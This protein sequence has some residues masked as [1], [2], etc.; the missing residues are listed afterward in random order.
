MGAQVGGRFVGRA[1]ELARLHALIDG[2]ERLITLVGPPG[3]GKTRLA[4]ELLAGRAEA[5]FCAIGQ[6]LDEE[7]V[8]RGLAAGLGVTVPA[9][10]A[11]SVQLARVLAERGPWVVV[12][13]NAEQVTAPLRALVDAWVAYAPEVRFVVTSRERLGL[14]YEVSHEL[15]ALPRA[16]EFG[17][18]SDAHVLLLDRVARAGKPIDTSLAAGERAALQRLT[19][20]LGGLPLAIEL[21][22]PR[23]ALLGAVAVEKRLAERSDLL[24]L[25]PL[26]T[27]LEWSWSLLTPDEQRSLAR[28]AVFVAGFDADAAGALLGAGAL[29]AL[30]AL[31]HKSL[32]VVEEGRFVFPFSVRDLAAEKV[33]VLGLRDAA[34]RAHARHYA[35]WGAAAAERAHR[36]DGLAALAAERDNLLAAAE[37]ALAR[38]P[39]DV[40]AAEEALASATALHAL[41]WTQGPFDGYEALL[42]RCL[43]AVSEGVARRGR[44]E[45]LAARG[46]ARRRLGRREEAEADLS[47]A[48]Q[49]AR[50][51]ADPVL[52]GRVTC[53]LG[54]L[55]A[56][57]RR[58]AEGRVALD[59]ALAC[60]REHDDRLGEA[61]AL[62]GLGLAANELGDAVD[63]DAMLDRATRLF[64]ETGARAMA[65]FA[66]THRVGVLASLGIV[67]EVERVHEVAMAAHREAGNRWFEAV[68]RANYASALLVRGA[69]REAIAELDHALPGLTAAGDERSWAV[70]FAVRALARHELGET[71]GARRELAHAADRVR[72]RRD[73]RATAT[74]LAWLGGVE[75]E[76]GALESS[77]RAFEEAARTLGALD[78][79]AARGILE[80]ERVL[81]LVARGRFAEAERT[82]G[83]LEGEDVQ[84]RSLER[85]FHLV[86]LSFDRVRRGLAAR[87]TSDPPAAGSARPAVGASGAVVVAGDGSRHELAR[88]ATLQ[89]LLRRLVVGLRET[90]GEAVASA[91][92]VAVGWPEERVGHDAAMNRLRVAVAR[93]RRLGLHDA[94]VGQHGGY[95]LVPGAVELR[96]A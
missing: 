27:T 38:A 30:E 3:V 95:L 35:A 10:G 65:G 17:E 79:R 50:D 63:A 93:L 90:P 12:L 91:E 2:T 45:A 18:T 37:R 80:A 71:E 67:D 6:A 25:A 23:V 84:G 73:P 51:A 7:G 41:A 34:E 29:E 13:D 61:H 75:A 42:T 77:E 82:F 72:G 52:E 66:A 46:Q 59:A 47:A 83:V 14:P 94:L 86:R 44:G 88:K 49:C 85:S 11:P 69:R 64:D 26:R 1:H 81:L 24:A 39:R 8:C 74:L 60:A 53:R 20:R 31:R 76:V 55:L 9:I 19:E 21:V 68:E 96:D 4:R 70:F 28:C 36:G 40:A 89:R 87:V 43:E 78:V 16:A 58:F 48:I 92:L 5:S 56:E 54:V 62:Y 15:G 32:L 33:E 57:A 22:A